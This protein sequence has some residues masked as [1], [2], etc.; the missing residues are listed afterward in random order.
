MT[1]CVERSF[2]SIVMV[3]FRPTIHVFFCVDRKKSWMVATS[4]T[5]TA[6]FGIGSA[7][8]PARHDPHKANRAAARARP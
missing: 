3:G 2:Y 6:L 5:M 4:A 7:A 8:S 1:A